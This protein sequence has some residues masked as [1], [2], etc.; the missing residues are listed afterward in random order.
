MTRS[1]RQNASSDETTIVAPA[2]PFGSGAVSIVRLSGPRAYPIADRL[3]G[4]DPRA[5]APRTLVRCVVRDE[6]GDPVDTALVAAFPAPH[7][8]TGEDV[9]EIHL[10]GNPLLVERAAAAACALGA[11]PA[12]PGEFSRRAF[13]NGK[14]DLTQA[15]GLADLVSARTAAAARA[16]LHQLRGGIAKTVGPLRE[17]LFGLLLGLEASIDFADEEDVPAPGADRIL[18]EIA[19]VRADLTRLIASYALGHRLRDGAT[20]AIAGVANVGKS[21]LLNRILGEDRAIVT[22]IPGT[23]RDYLSADIVLDGLPA[24]IVDTAGLRETEDVVEREGARRSREIVAAA[25]L[26]LFVLDGSRA[27]READAAAYRE[28]QGRP[29]LVVLNK[30]DLAHAEDGSRFRGEGFRE[31][32]RVSALTGAGLEALRRLMARELVPGA[33]AA[34]AAPLTR[35][36]HVEAARRADLA[37][38]R[39]EDAVRA[40]MSHE[41]AAADVREAAA[42]LSELVGEIAPEDVL[43]AIFG[44]FCIGK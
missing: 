21:L 24:R 9:V 10:H 27:A 41:F 38:A 6:A 1:G 28:A 12:A 14:M 23:T 16:A 31:A 11:V 4:R 2:T 15:E 29:H 25:D 35:L 43:D 22:E 5:L 32:L 18:E 7:S 40:G 42:A 36:R 44:S 39:A 20:V 17:R 3:T 33:A 37:L 34:A 26:V 13:Q 30:A 19:A 8:A